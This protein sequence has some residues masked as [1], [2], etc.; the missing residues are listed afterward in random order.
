M[1]NLLELSHAGWRLVALLMGI[2]KGEIKA[3]SYIVM[4]AIKTTLT[5][6]TLDD[7]AGFSWIR[8]LKDAQ[9]LEK[10]IPIAISDFVYDYLIDFTEKPEEK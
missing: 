2:R 5:L 10:A 1:K 6:I 9:Q 7:C 3:E 8:I 4:S